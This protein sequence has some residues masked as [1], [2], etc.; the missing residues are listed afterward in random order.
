MGSS[1]TAAAAIAGYLYEIGA[2]RSS[3][4]VISYEIAPSSIK[5]MVRRGRMR[6]DASIVVQTKDGV[7]KRGV[8]VLLK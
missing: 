2:L 1:Y 6:V 4:Q 3:A 8:V 5:R 7:K